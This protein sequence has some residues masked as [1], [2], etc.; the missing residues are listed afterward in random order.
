[1]N[2]IEKIIIYKLSSKVNLEYGSFK[3][4]KLCTLLVEIIS[5]G[6]SGWGEC[7]GRK[8]RKFFDP[9]KYCVGLGKKIIG[10][11]LE[12]PSTVLQ[13]SESRSLANDKWSWG[14]NGAFRSAREAF[15]IATYD[16]FGRITNKSVSNLL[17]SKI[18][19]SFPGMPV[20]HMSSPEKMAKTAEVWTKQK[21]FK[22]LKIKLGRDRCSERLEAIRKMVGDDVDLHVDFNHSL[23]GYDDAV[24]LISNLHKNFSLS[25]VEDP[26][27]GMNS[28][29]RKLRGDIEPKLMM[30]SGTFWPHIRSV[31]KSGAVDIINHHTCQQGGLDLALLISKVASAYGIEDAVGSSGLVGV[32]EIAFQQLAGVIGFSRP[33]ES[34]LFADNY[35]D[36]SFE[37]YY[38]IDGISVIEGGHVQKDGIIYLN[39]K[40]GLGMNVNRDTVNKYAEQT[41]MMEYSKNRNVKLTVGA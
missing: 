40:S 17:A 29:F 19:D 22:F 9:Y 15:S 31:A 34:L 3:R 41:V 27:R 7:G 2:N 8:W 25:I 33:C 24:R 6:L 18:R 20:I 5:E 38:G 14:Y 1:M 37:D 35:A 28:T 10:R 21:G 36:K 30:D 39:G 32:S 11:K 4:D 16:L 26:F 23:R 12:D 13:E